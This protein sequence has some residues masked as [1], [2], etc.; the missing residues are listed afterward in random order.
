[1]VTTDLAV[2]IWDVAGAR[3]VRNARSAELRKFSL[4]AGYRMPD[5]LRRGRRMANGLPHCAGVSEF[6]RLDVQ[7]GHCPDR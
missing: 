2:R 6:F 3:L 5:T 4:T 7:A 1:M